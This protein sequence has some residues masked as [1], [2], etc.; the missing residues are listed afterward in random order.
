MRLQWKKL[1]DYAIEDQTGQFRVCRTRVHGTWGY[2][3][4]RRVTRQEEQEEGDMPSVRWEPMCYTSDPTVAKA[5]CEMA[6]NIAA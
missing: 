2:T 3:T 5:T 4:W 1:S 6:L